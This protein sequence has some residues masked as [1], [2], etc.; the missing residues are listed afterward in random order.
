MFPGSGK[1]NN[2]CGEEGCQGKRLPTCRQA[3]LQLGVPKSKS[4]EHL[5]LWKLDHSYKDQTRW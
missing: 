4:I 2:F 3:I 5:S 1:S